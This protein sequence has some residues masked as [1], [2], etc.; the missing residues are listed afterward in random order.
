[1]KVIIVE[2][3]IIA[4]KKLEELLKRN[5]AS[6]KVLARLESVKE[7]VKWIENNPSPDVGFFDIQ[8]ADATSF[9]IF[10]QCNVRFPVVFVTAY[11]DYLLEAFE[12]NSIH[13]LLK[14]VTGEKVKKA[15]QKIRQFEKHFLSGMEKFLLAKKES[16]EYKKQIIVKKGIY[17]VPMNA[18]E[19]AYIF[20]EHKISFVCTNSDDLYMTDQ[21]LSHLEN[22]LDPSLF[23]KANRQYCKID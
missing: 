6:L 13:Y 7:A 14:P 16:E 20:S 1:M 5:V 18:E 22:I 10:E 8:L 17:N 3:E 21:P 2:D 12:H 23:F 15:L 19:I 4:T 11:D 9:D